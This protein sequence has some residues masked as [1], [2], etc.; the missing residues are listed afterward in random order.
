MR[1]HELRGESSEPLAARAVFHQFVPHGLANGRLGVVERF[2]PWS[3]A[4][5]LNPGWQP[6]GAELVPHALNTWLNANGPEPPLMPVVRFPG[7]GHTVVVMPHLWTIAREGRVT[8]WRVQIPLLLAYALTVHKCQVDL[9]NVFAFGQ[10]YTA[11][12]RIRSLVRASPLNVRCIPQKSP[13]DIHPLSAHRRF[14]AH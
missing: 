11:V 5:E 13:T 9:T 12:S 1:H 3:Q 10:A 14:P 2:I 6:I 4:M 7:A 8:C